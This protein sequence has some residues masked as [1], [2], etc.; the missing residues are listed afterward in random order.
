[1]GPTDDIDEIASVVCGPLA[2]A[3]SD[4]EIA[5]SCF[6]R[7]LRDEL[8]GCCNM[9]DRSRGGGELGDDDGV[10]SATGACVEEDDGGG[11]SGG[12]E[13]V[14]TSEREGAECD[15]WLEYNAFG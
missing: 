6:R 1:M 14:H 2:S 7:S 11:G 12:G 4:A 3:R 5:S 10:G 13:A 15:S 9:V 8:N